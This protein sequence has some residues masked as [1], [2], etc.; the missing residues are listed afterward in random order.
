MIIGVLFSRVLFVGV[1]YEVF[2]LDYGIS[3]VKYVVVG[4]VDELREVG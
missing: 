3:V 1:V 2:V 4:V